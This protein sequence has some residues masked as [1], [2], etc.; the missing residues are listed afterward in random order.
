MCVCVIYTLTANK[1]LKES[2]RKFVEYQKSVNV[3]VFF[4]APENYFLPQK[5]ISIDTP[6][7]EIYTKR[8]R[9]KKHKTHTVNRYKKGLK[10]N[11][12]INFFVYICYGFVFISVFFFDIQGMKNDLR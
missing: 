11:R 8:E 6:K 3:F 4:L 9:E 7:M 12:V 5:F 1:S 10:K 2:L